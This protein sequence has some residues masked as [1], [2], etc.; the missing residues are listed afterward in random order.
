MLYPN[1]LRALR[2]PFPKRSLADCCVARVL[3][4]H[5]CLNTL[6]FRARGTP[7]TRLNQ[8]SG[9]APQVRFILPD[10]QYR[11]YSRSRSSMRSRPLIQI[12]NLI[13][14]RSPNGF[15]RIIATPPSRSTQATGLKLVGVERFELPTH[16]SQ[17]SCA[18][19]LRYTPTLALGQGAE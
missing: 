4:P 7:C 13:R 5:V 15:D 9:K 11:D 1:E 8:A 2:I 16:C 17:S 12:L 18:T 3:E 19:R 10:F 6:R 14:C